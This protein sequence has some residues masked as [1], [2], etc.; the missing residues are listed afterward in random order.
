MRRYRIGGLLSALALAGV[1]ATGGIAQAQDNVQIQVI[2]PGT[3]ATPVGDSFLANPVTGVAN[4]ATFA[5]DQWTGAAM[6]TDA[7]IYG[8]LGAALYAQS[9][10]LGTASLNFQL[11]NVPT[12]DVTLY[13]VGIDDDSETKAPIELTINTKVVY[14]GDS[15]FEDW[16]G[17]VGEGNWTTVQIT[18]PKGMLGG[19]GNAITLSVTTA[20]GH[21]GEAPYVILGGARLEVPGTTIYLTQ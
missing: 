15:W 12:G 7:G 4:V 10:G 11:D 17:T 14:T 16:G 8:R 21:E 3:P 20:D 1:M 18:I 5:P 2:T 6:V 19:G 13:L 9:T